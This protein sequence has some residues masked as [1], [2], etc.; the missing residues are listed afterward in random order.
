MKD[1][2]TFAPAGAPGLEAAIV[3]SPLIQ[4]GIKGQALFFSDTIGVIVDLSTTTGTASIG[5]ERD[6][7]VGIEVLYGGTAA[8]RGR[9]NTM[10][11]KVTKV[12]KHSNV[13]IS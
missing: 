1:S 2:I 5:A 9:R 13:S 10:L 4:P 11:T 12:T 8:D 7:I 6:Q 3:E